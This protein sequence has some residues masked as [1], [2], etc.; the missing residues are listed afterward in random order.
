M[1]SYKYF[2]THATFPL[3]FPF[4]IIDIMLFFYKKKS[5]NIIKVI[6]LFGGMLTYYLFRKLS[7]IS[8]TLGTYNSESVNGESGIIET[9]PVRAENNAMIYDGHL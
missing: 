1:I 2:D 3:T 9:I 6:Y 5:K 4:Y 7:I 8:Q